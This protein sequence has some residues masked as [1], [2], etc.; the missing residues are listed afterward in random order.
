[1]SCDVRIQ[2]QCSRDHPHGP[3]FLGLEVT[4]SISG[5]RWLLSPQSIRNV[6]R[7]HGLVWVLL[8]IRACWGGVGAGQPPVPGPALT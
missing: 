3:R 4:S 2:R 7:G 1:M 8:P 6:C 5:Q